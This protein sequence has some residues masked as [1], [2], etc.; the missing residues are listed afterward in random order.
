MQYRMDMYV[1]PFLFTIQQGFKKLSL[2]LYHSKHPVSSKTGTFPRTDNG[3]VD[4][5]SSYTITPRCE[6]RGTQLFS[7]LLRTARPQI[8]GTCYTKIAK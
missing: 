2:P 1:T 4:L 6:V 8:P 5:W 7:K 3:A